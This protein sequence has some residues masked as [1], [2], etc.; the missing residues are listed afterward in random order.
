MAVAGARAHFFE[1]QG[2]L[3]E[4]V[5]SRNRSGVMADVIAEG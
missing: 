4:G 5:E 2:I 3:R 1:K